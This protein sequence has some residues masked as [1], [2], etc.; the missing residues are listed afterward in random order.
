MALKGHDMDRYVIPYEVPAETPLQAHLKA[1]ELLRTG[2]AVT[3]VIRIAPTVPGWFEVVLGV[4]EPENA[5]AITAAKALAED[6]A[7]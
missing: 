1:S 4:E 3:E 5:D 7:R 2:V 6:Y